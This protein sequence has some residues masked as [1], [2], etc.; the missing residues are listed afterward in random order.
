MSRYV[1][2][3]NVWVMAAKSG[4]V[5]EISDEAEIDATELCLNWL[6]QFA[7]SHDQMVVDSALIYRILKEY[8]HNLRAQSLA[9]DLLNQL[10]RQPRDRIVDIAIKVDHDGYALVPTHLAIADRNDRKFIAVVLG[11]AP[12]QP[13]IV[14]GTDTDWDKEKDRL[15][16]GGIDIHEL[17]P[18]YIRQ[19]RKS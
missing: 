1:I 7:Q 3:T 4:K 8:L 2:E 19:K 13:P 14:N 15:I 9:R 10:E 18:H 11:C 12:D 16:V 17:C 5:N 6:R